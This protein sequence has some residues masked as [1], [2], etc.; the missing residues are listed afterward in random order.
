MLCLTTLTENHIFYKIFV[1]TGR[2]D[3]RIGLNRGV[4][5]GFDGP[6][7]T[8][9]N[10][11]GTDWAEDVV[12]AVTADVSVVDGDGCWPSRRQKLDEKVEDLMSTDVEG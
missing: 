9:D 12:S 4:G 3:I 2:L 8:G 6:A 10:L 5:E 7:A 11:V 1:L